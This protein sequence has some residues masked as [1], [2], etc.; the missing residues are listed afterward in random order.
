MGSVASLIDST[1]EFFGH[2]WRNTVAGLPSPV[3]PFVRPA[4]TAAAD[5][6]QTT[7]HL[8]RLVETEIIPRLVLAHQLAPNAVSEAMDQVAD[9][10]EATD[11]FTDLVLS[12]DVDDLTA[13]VDTLLHSGRSMNS[14]YLDLLAPTARRLGD[15]WDQDRISFT[16]VTIGVGRLQHLVRALSWRTE[17]ELEETASR[18][19]YFIPS[20]SEQHTFGLFILEDIFQRAGWRTWI[21]TSATDDQTI[22]AV[23]NQ[24]FDL[25]GVS[26]SRDTQI[27]EVAATIAA[28]RGASRNP[29]LFILVGGRLFMEQPEIVSAVGADAIASSGDHA[30]LVADEV[31]MRRA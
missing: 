23:R 31:F 2:Y 10:D 11:V 3:A 27:D 22:R 6:T 15:Y 28:A 13:F 18:S 29:D 4:P 25:L 26:A 16:D 7:S 14:I 5:S 17:Q 8:A 9:L 21:E 24:W 1:S 19:A 20:L 12:R 30:L